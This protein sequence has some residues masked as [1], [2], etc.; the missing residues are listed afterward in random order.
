MKRMLLILA[1]L[2]GLQ[3]AHP[4]RA[5]DQPNIVVFVS[6]DHRAD[7]LGC[8][9]HPVARTPNLDRI[10]ANGHRFSNA[11]VTTSI[12]AAS[13]ATILT[14]LTERTHRFTFGR[15][16][17]AENHC[18]AS[19]P[20]QLRNNGY[21]TGFVGK[22]GLSVQ[23]GRS[24]INE[25]FD[26]F[27]PL[28][29]SPYFKTLPD[30]GTRHLTD[31]TGDKAIEFLQT[32]DPDTPFCL[33]VSFNATHAEDGDQEDH[34][35]FPPTEAELF[36]DLEMP[37][38][39][40]D[41]ETHFPNQP[42]FL[43][44]SMNRNRYFWRWDTPEKYQH[45]YRNYL[46]MLAGV[47]R[48]VGRVIDELERLGI[49]DNTVIIFI[50]D[51]G[52][53]MGER[54]FAGKWS[55]YEPSL[56]VP[57]VIM[58]P[59]NSGESSKGVI[60]DIA[61]NLDLAPTVLA[62]AGAEPQAAHQGRSL[63]GNIRKPPTPAPAPGFFCEH[64]MK[65]PDLPRWEGYRDNQ[66]KYAR[67]IDQ[68]EDG[69]FL[70]DLINDPDELVNLINDESHAET[71]IRM[72][73]TCKQLSRAYAGQANPMPRVL[74]LG[75]SISMGY[76]QSVKNALDDEAMLFRPQEN[77][78]GT[79]HGCLRIDDWLKIDGGHFD[80]IHFNFGLHDLKRENPDGKASNNPDDDNQADLQT[81]ERQLRRIVSRLKATEARLIFATT[82][83][84]PE[85]EVR[86]H[87]DPEDVDRYNEIARQVMAEHEIP[88]N[89]L[90]A[91]AS[92]RLEDI[93]RPANVHFTTMGS[94][95]LGQQVAAQLRKILR[96]PGH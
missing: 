62:L 88:I 89:D 77:C 95:T 37:R 66:F 83:P 17:L 56:R 68:P 84:V 9:G 53:Y 30:G 50:G 71:L 59:R 60:D 25:M 12:C 87:R 65:H 57:L 73:E 81:Y 32:T 14:G 5:E 22:I 21:R 26:S 96:Q 69:E 92:S 55:H 1:C 43:K 16:P 51:N 82:T 67:Y 27:T 41:G 72:R 52:Y 79:T 28:N 80:V 38:P 91:F 10:A 49:A 47:D 23:G 54:G 36:K 40:L 75:D 39:R 63:L 58:D 42:A 11:F 61:L 44:S 4:A 29:R 6:D 15:P 86:P 20:Y 94:N 74:L 85:G 8:A 76:N 18:K 31:L 46:R 48:N 24:T 33:S 13:R 90:F 64:R 35:P 2:L 3:P 45:N 34:Y 7:L 19:Y 70:H 93:Q 78:A